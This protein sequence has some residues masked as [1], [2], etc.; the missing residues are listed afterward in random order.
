MTEEVFLPFS[1][2]L[3]LHHWI[4]GSA[5]RNPFIGDGE[6]RWSQQELSQCVLPCQCLFTHLQD[7]SSAASA[8]CCSCSQQ[9]L[10]SCFPHDASGQKPLLSC[11]LAGLQSSLP[12]W[13]GLLSQSLVYGNFEDVQLVEVQFHAELRPAALTSLTSHS[14]RWGGPWTKCG[15]GA[16]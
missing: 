11:R 7:T 3:L 14:V 9:A 2:R 5:W 12:C 15:T 10:L 13:T 1:W 16:G 8:K 6:G 4:V